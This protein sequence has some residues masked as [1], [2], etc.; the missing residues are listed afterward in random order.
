M[1]ANPD[2][3]G[4]VFDAHVAAEFKTR[5]IQATMATMAA[6]PHVTPRPDHDRR[7]RP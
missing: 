6:K 3:L 1:T 7:P 2:K 5:D 4:E